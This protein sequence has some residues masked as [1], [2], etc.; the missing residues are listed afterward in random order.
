MRPAHHRATSQ[1]K[2]KKL[3]DKEDN[4]IVNHVKALVR[5]EPEEPPVQSDTNLERPD[6]QIPRS[7]I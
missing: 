3:F 2:R 5:I 7:L 4:K 6:G 1:T